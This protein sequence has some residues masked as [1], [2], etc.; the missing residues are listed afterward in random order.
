MAFEITQQDQQALQSM[1]DAIVARGRIF[2]A[3]QRRRRMHSGGAVVA[4]GASL[5]IKYVLLE[6]DIKGVT[7]D[8]PTLFM[9]DTYEGILSDAERAASPPWTV[10]FQDPM[11]NDYNKNH[12]T[13][14]NL[15]G[16]TGRAVELKYFENEELTL[17]GV[18]SSNGTTTTV[19]LQI[20]NSSA[21]TGEYVG[22]TIEITDGPGDGQV[23]TVIAYDGSTRKVT[24]DATSWTT[25]PQKNNSSYTLTRSRH[26]RL[27]TNV[28]SD[29]ANKRKIVR[30]ALTTIYY[31]D[32]KDFKVG[33]YKRL[34]YP[35]YPEN[36]QFPP[37]GTGTYQK[38]SDTYFNRKYRGIAIN[39]V[40][41][42]GLCKPLPPPKLI[43]K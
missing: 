42:V 24:V 28:I 19:Y 29:D 4:P 30:Y 39:S 41:V 18:C 15:F 3:A 7:E 21:I 35:D 14:F 17:S 34:D 16:Y 31:D 9:T 25:A 11:D 22:D 5:D 26:R 38:M 23:G 8:D 36:E 12:L 6:A 2:P 1:R 10:V 32:G 20:N 40:L 43:P 37:D 13:K 27:A 33:T